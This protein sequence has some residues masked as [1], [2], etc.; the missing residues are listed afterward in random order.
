MWVCNTIF[1]SSYKSRW[2]T[3]IEK[4]FLPKRYTCDILSLLCLKKL[5]FKN[6]FIYLILVIVVVRISDIRKHRNP[7]VK[8]W[9]KYLKFRFAKAE[10]SSQIF[11]PLHYRS[12][13]FSLCCFLFNFKRFIFRTTDAINVKLYMLDYKEHMVANKQ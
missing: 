7:N 2:L 4:Y 5:N 11:I 12:Y 1:F 10:R 6:S 9:M 13:L 8:V 3:I